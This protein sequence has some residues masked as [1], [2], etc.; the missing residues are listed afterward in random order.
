[1]T[2]VQNRLQLLSGNKFLAYIVILLLSSCA[3]PKVISQNNKA[4]HVEPDSLTNIDSLEGREIV[5]KDNF[6][7]SIDKFYPIAL[8]DTYSVAF[9]MPLFADYY[10]E[11]EANKKAVADIALDF[12]WGASIALDTLADIGLNATVNI[13][14]T[15][16]DTQITKSHKKGLLDAKTDLIIGP[17][18]SSNIEV[19]AD[20]SK[21]NNINLA[22]PLANLNECTKKHERLFF[23]KTDKKYIDLAY[24]KIIP[25]LFSNKHPIFIYT[26]NS[27]ADIQLANDIKD[28]LP[29]QYK[30]QVQIKTIDNEYIS[31]GSLSSSYKD[32]T[33]VIIL[34]AKDAFV[35][36]I[37]AEMRRSLKTF[38]I[39]GQEKWLK[40]TSLDAEVFTKLNARI[41]SSQYFDYSLPMMKS[42]IKNY[43]KKYNAEPS[44]YAI[45]G[46]CE[47]L[48]YLTY[49]K[50]YGV[51]FQRF[52]GDIKLTLPNGGYNIK[53]NASCKHFENCKMHILYFDNNQL[54]EMK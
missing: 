17:F 51:N 11:I 21:N 45:L 9:M 10:P 34:S 5:T 40:F 2:L 25:K 38:Y 8:K 35:N 32:T 48:F 22:A 39:L 26:T 18:F 4:I 16:N 20:F 1:M 23:S 28:S 36:S 19:L 30:S 47:T 41:I 13:Y 50:H 6:I 14:D 46:Y 33:I 12:W 31:R 3:G 49:L 44:E 24:S 7:D 37:I 29:N 27:E 43:R 54:I 53:Q 42:F 52:M 15:Q